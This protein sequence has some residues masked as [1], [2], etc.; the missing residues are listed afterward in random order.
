MI[1]HMHACVGVCT[2]FDGVNFTQDHPRIVVF[3]QQQGEYKVLDCFMGAVL[4]YG[5]LPGMNS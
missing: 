4:S 3:N 1:S 2:Y 5:R